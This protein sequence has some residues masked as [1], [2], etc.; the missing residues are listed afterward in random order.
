M[1]SSCN[2]QLDIADWLSAIH[3]ERYQDS[4]RLHGYNRVKDILSVDNEVLQKIGVGATGHR[5][6]IMSRLR[7]ISGE[8]NSLPTLRDIDKTETQENSSKSLKDDPTNNKHSSNDKSGDSESALKPVPKPRTV[9]NK[10]NVNA[11]KTASISAIQSPVSLDNYSSVARRSSLQETVVPRGNSL[12]TENCNSCLEPK[13]GGVELE[14]GIPKNTSA[15]AGK[16]FHPIPSLPMRQNKE[17]LQPGSSYQQPKTQMEADTM[18]CSPLSSLSSFAGNEEEVTSFSTNPSSP[19]ETLTMISNEI[20]SGFGPRTGCVSCAPD[21]EASQIHINPPDMNNQETASTRE[22]KKSP[23]MMNSTQKPAQMRKTPSPTPAWIREG[24]SSRPAPLG[25]SA[26]PTASRVRTS[27]PVRQVP[28]GFQAH[29]PP[30]QKK[31]ILPVTFSAASLRPNPVGDSGSPRLPRTGHAAFPRPPPIGHSASPLLPRGKNSPPEVTDITQN[32]GPPITNPASFKQTKK[33]QLTGRQDVTG[34]GSL[35]RQRSVTKNKSGADVR[36]ASTGSSLSAKDMSHRPTPV[37]NAGTSNTPSGS[38]PSQRSFLMRYTIPPRLPMAKQ[39]PTTRVSAIKPISPA[40]LDQDVH[41]KNLAHVNDNYESKRPSPMGMS[42]SSTLKKSFVGKSA[43][44]IS[45]TKAAVSGLPTPKSKVGDS[46]LANQGPLDTTAK[47]KTKPAGWVPRT[48]CIGIAATQ[49]VKVTKNDLLPQPKEAEQCP[50]ERTKAKGSKFLL[51]QKPAEKNGLS[52]QKSAGSITFQRPKQTGN[53]G[54]QTAKCRNVSSTK[55]S[56]QNVTVPRPPGNTEVARPVSSSAISLS[57]VI[58]K[59]PSARVKQNDTTTNTTTARPQTL[60]TKAIPSKSRGSPNYEKPNESITRTPPKKLG[61]QLLPRLPFMQKKSSKMTIMKSPV[62]RAGENNYLVCSPGWKATPYVTGVEEDNV[63]DPVQDLPP[64]EDSLDLHN[65]FPDPWDKTLTEESLEAALRANA[66][67]FRPIQDEHLVLVRP[68]LLGSHISDEYLE[69]KYGISKAKDGCPGSS[70]EEL[71]LVPERPISSLVTADALNPYCETVFNRITQTQEPKDVKN[72]KI[73]TCSTMPMFTPG[74]E[75]NHLWNAGDASKEKK[76][77]GEDGKT[78]RITQIVHNEQEGYSTV[79]SPVD[80][81]RFSLPSHLYTD[82]I[83]DD[84]T[85]SPYASFTSMHDKSRPV[86]V[87]WL[88]KLSPQGNYV[89]QRRFVKFD[90]N[91]LMYFSNDKDIYSK[92]VIP[93][94]S[95]EMARSTKENKFE[96]VTKHR[97][98]VFRAENEAQRSEWCST[99]Q[100]KVKEQRM[101]NPRSR[102]SCVLFGQK[103]GYLELKGYKSKI[104]AVLT[105]DQLWIHKNEQFFKMGIGMFVIDLNGSTIR[106]ARNKTFELITPHK[107]FSFTA[108]SEREKKEWMEAILECISESLSDYE[109]AEKIWSNKANKY[110]ADCRTCNPDWASINLCVIICKQCAGQHRSL[111]SNI[112]KVQSL[113]LDTSIWSNEIVQLFIILGNDRANRFWAARLPPSEIL[114]PEDN[115]EQRR[116]FIAH[117]YRDGK[118][119]SPHPNYSTQEEILKVLSSAVAG[120]NLLKT[121][122]QFFS[123]AESVAEPFEDPTLSTNSADNWRASSYSLNNE[124]LF[125]DDSNQG[126][127]YDEIMQPVVHSGYLNKATVLSKTS[128]AKKSK[129]EF[130]R[131]WCVLERSLIFYENDRSSEQVG[132]INPSEVVCLGVNKLDISN[133]PAPVERFRYTFE[134]FLASEK[135]HQFGTDAAETLQTWT[136]AIGKWFSPISCHCLLVYEFQRVGKMRYKA[137]LNPDQWKEGFF[138][139]QKSHLFICP[140]EQN[141]AEDSVNLRRLQELTVSPATENSEKKDILILVEKGRTLYLQGITRADFLAWGSDIQAAACSSGNML[142]DQQLSRN[143]IPIIVDSCIAFLTQYGLR[144]EGIYRKNGAKSRIKLLMDEFRKDA[145]NVKLRISDNFVEDVTDVLKRFFRELDDP[146]FTTE[147]HPQWREAAEHQEKSKRLEK[148]ME[149]INSLPKVNRATSAALIGHLYRVQKCADLN[150]MCTKN[151][152]LLFA[153]SLF[154]TEGKG[155]HE[156]KIMEDLID[157]YP[158]V[159]SIDEEQV[160]QMDLENSLITTWKDVQL[161]QAGDLIIEVYLERKE[162]DCCVT[163]KVSPVMTAEELTNQVLDMRNIPASTDI[164]LTFEVFENGELERPLHPKERVLEQALQWCKLAEPSSAYLLVKKISFTE[165]SCLFTGTK[166]ETPKCGLL[167]CREET[168]KLLASKFQERYFVIKDRKLLLLKEKKSSK[169]EREWTLETAKVY[170]GI[171][172]KVK[173]P[174]PWGFTIHLDKQQLC[175]CCTTQAEMWDWITSIL[176]AQ[177]D[178]LRPVILRRHSSSDVTKQKFGTMPLVPI[179][180]DDT[181]STMVTA[182]QTLPMKMHQDSLEELQEKQDDDEY[183]PVYEEVGNFHSLPQA[184]LDCILSTERL[185]LPP[186]LDR[187]K[188]PVLNPNPDQTKTTMPVSPKPSSPEKSDKEHFTKTQS[189]DRS[190]CMENIKTLSSDSNKTGMAD[191]GVGP[192]MTKSNSLERQVDL[193]RNQLGTSRTQTGKST[194][195]L[196]TLPLFFE[197]TAPSDSSKVPVWKKTS[198]LSMNMQDK[199]VQELNTMLNKKNE[200]GSGAGQQV[201]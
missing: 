127:V 96:V 83:T 119:R 196:S 69:Q 32:D 154:Q 180:G 26:S 73:R 177:H 68:R 12:D 47:P 170:M 18:Q 192:S 1:T 70:E 197:P 116:D 148:Y 167:K 184:E 193:S 71:P 109:V 133:S 88:D 178:D 87:G 136:S 44:I 15:E 90:G 123:D 176:K 39:S 169:P 145:R 57:K 104:F 106:D 45:S 78:Q 160:T 105:T 195:D 113:K 146:I 29:P 63:T 200:S 24:V 131:H 185:Q 103:F 27:A 134:I 135:V 89:F 137:M 95:I 86:L 147:R 138:L 9:F 62:S 54:S 37:G 91:N 16:S 72:G 67:I 107:T 66:A 141:A 121:V 112:S 55:N 114:H 128:T 159:F 183:E 110:C 84:M 31:N 40:C 30:S 198:P 77:E 120:P 187:T 152:A 43:S 53:T 65:T 28:A 46:V 142:R 140:E 188:K 126:R 143:D 172:K 74:E 21:T 48:K 42:P 8:S 56:Q 49:K 186:P 19:Q 2:N 151:L 179:R 101:F 174:T 14:A 94:A 191:R 189:L 35:Q 58:K 144:H 36:V 100:N 20:Y 76:N 7:H 158:S 201:T 111:G 82:E 3:L 122:M 80:K 115:I 129:D 181:N 161:S 10:Y 156:V 118:Y 93:L 52:I 34:N 102:S 79:D 153:P 125:P 99:I 11:T 124:G 25:I 59:T 81:N 17:S 163:L 171:K 157:N 60:G 108:E 22:R 38:V 194:L 98:F 165:G 166:R 173:P 6:R 149:L 199:L 50:A 190:L 97:I 117:K 5:K 132:K 33:K 175:L 164:W 130:H 85:I 155:E 51:K 182:N 64:V 23:P 139:L 4:F 61:S 92:G 13:P 162:Q 150:Q 41:E 75:R 168:P